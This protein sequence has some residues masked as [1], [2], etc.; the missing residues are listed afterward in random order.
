MLEGHAVVWLTVQQGNYLD[1]SII[2]ESCIHEESNR[3]Y[4]K[5]F[6]ARKLLQLQK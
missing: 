6:V 2:W 1:Q 5:Y 3:D 4:E